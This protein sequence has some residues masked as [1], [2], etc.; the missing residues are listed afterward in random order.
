VPKVGD[1]GPWIPTHFE[2]SIIGRLL[3]NTLS[4]DY[5]TTTPPAPVFD[6]EQQDSDRAIA[7]TLGVPWPVPALRKSAMLQ[8]L[9]RCRIHGFG[10]P[11]SG[12]KFFK[13]LISLPLLRDVLVDGLQGGYSNAIDDLE[14]SVSCPQVKT[15]HL[16]SCQ[17]LTSEAS[18]IVKCCPN[19]STLE[20]AWEMRNT[21]KRN[22][23]SIRAKR[24]RFGEI[25]DSIARHTPNL[26]SLR[27]SASCYPYRYHSFNHPF[28]IGSALQQ[29]E[30][31][32]SGQC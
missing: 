29:L 22:Q 28:K 12:L 23:A 16:R 14:I 8:N 24:L 4:T 2:T 3:D 7:E 9:V 17:L 20:I 21:S 30:H 11:P 27:L 1:T 10:T 15:L 32:E 5:Q 18:S 19:L 26:S 31:L 25:G 13:K 6:A